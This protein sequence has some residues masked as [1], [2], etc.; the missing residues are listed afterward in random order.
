MPP[1]GPFICAR[2][3]GATVHVT[4]SILFIR[5]IPFQEISMTPTRA[6]TKKPATL[7][8]KAATPVRAA[9]ARKRAAG[10]ST[11]AVKSSPAKKVLAAKDKVSAHPAKTPPPQTAGQA[12]T[13]AD[14]AAKPAKQ[15]LVR[16]SFTI[17]RAEYAVLGALKERSVRLAKPAKKS[18][19]LRA[20][21]KLLSAQTDAALLAALAAV[22]SIKTGRPKKAK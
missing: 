11:P 6:M 21:I 9:A 5:F 17:P 12:Q 14:A 1:N 10:P 18:E 2:R 20:A 4:A 13:A 16:D 8:A 3:G 15:K 7:A 19:V 22:P